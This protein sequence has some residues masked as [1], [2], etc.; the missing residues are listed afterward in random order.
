M[1][2]TYIIHQQL[3]INSEII[4]CLSLSNGN[5]VAIT[6]RVVSSCSREHSSFLRG[7]EIGSY[8]VNWK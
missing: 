8:A 2:L 3:Y 7:N 4:W 6:S 5:L 1:R